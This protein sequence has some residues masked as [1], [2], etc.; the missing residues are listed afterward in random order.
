[1]SARHQSVPFAPLTLLKMIIEGYGI[2]VVLRFVVLGPPARDRAFYCCM[3]HDRA[4]TIAMPA[5]RDKTVI[6]TA[7][8][9]TGAS[10]P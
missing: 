3:F 5:K 1:M 7:I 10:F 8:L 6:D 4:P 2:D 9:F